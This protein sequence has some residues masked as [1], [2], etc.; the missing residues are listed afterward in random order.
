MQSYQKEETR[1]INKPTIDYCNLL[2]NKQTIDNCNLLINKQTNDNCNLLI[3]KRTIDNCNLIINKQ[4][5]DVI[6]S[7]ATLNG[8]L[9]INK[10][11]IDNYNL[12]N[13]QY[14]FWETQQLD[15]DTYWF[16]QLNDYTY[17]IGIA[18]RFYLSWN[19]YQLSTKWC[20]MRIEERNSSTL[21]L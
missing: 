19:T 1:L 15:S 9:L 3:N 6:T 20:N 16:E 8:N 10:Q 7:T 2:I 5:I 18:L 17:S 12:L 21:R 13:K 11:T 14:I 4:T